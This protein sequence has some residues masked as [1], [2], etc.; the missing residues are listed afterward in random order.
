MSSPGFEQATTCFPACRSNHSAI[1]AVNDML[2]NLLQHFF[3]LLLINTCGNACMKLILV[4]CY[5]NWLSDKIRISFTNIHVDVNYYCIQNFVW[6]NQTII[7]F[8]LALSH[9]LID[10]SV[11]SSVKVLTSCRQLSRQPSG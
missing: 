10:S 5:W 6:T 3:M 7:N 2:L 9:M 11:K 8:T 1:G 4:W